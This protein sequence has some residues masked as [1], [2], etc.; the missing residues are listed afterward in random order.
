MQ[1]HIENER[2]KKELIEANSKAHQQLPSTFSNQPRS[3]AVPQLHQQQSTTPTQIL[4]L[5]RPVISQATASLTIT[6]DDELQAQSIVNSEALTVS[7]D[8]PVVAAAASSS[9]SKRTREEEK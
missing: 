3:A 6:G 9:L 1:I 5:K 4:S 7:A 2:L 8:A